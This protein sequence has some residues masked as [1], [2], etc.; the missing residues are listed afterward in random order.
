MRDEH[1]DVVWPASA[2]EDVVILCEDRKGRVDAL[3]E[4]ELLGARLQR[5]AEKAQGGGGL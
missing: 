3:V 4:G 1:R 2:P 5:G